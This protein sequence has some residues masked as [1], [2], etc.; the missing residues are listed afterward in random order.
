MEILTKPAFGYNETD[1]NTKTFTGGTPFINDDFV[2]PHDKENNPMVFFCQIC[3]DEVD[4]RIIKELNLPNKGFLQFYH[5]GDDLMGMDLDFTEGSFVFLN[6]VSQILYIEEAF[7]KEFELP[8]YKEEM[9]Y[10]PV[11]Q[12]VNGD[13]TRVF[14]E[15][16]YIEMLPYP[17]S[18]DNPSITEFD[19]YGEK[20]LN[21]YEEQK[22][23]S[24]ELYLGGY[25]HFTQFDFRDE[26]TDLE[27]L[28]GSESGKEIMWGDVG[29]GAFWIPKK[30]FQKQN[31][32]NSIIYWDCG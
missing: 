7:D 26:K 22:E 20:Y 15:G 16:E 5:G 25:P 27:I 3:L 23:T 28:L 14:Y 8:Q 2:F 11:E 29:T 31:Y 32:S 10:S 30:D 17:N 6:N 9:D 19:K 21:Y 1:K 18:N 24:C 4:E 13:N 12:I